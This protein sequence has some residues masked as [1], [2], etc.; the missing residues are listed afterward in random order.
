ML[1]EKENEKRKKNWD[2]YLGHIVVRPL[3]K[4]IIGATLMKHYPDKT[5]RHYTVKRPYPVNVF[6]KELIISSLPY[7]EQDGIVG[8]CAS[9]ALWCAFQHT[10]HLFNSQSH[11]PSD[12][13][14]MA[15]LD[16]LSPT[17]NYTANDLSGEQINNAIYSNNLVPEAKTLEHDIK[18]V[19]AFLYAYLRMGIPVLLGLKEDK[20]GQGHLV[21]LC[22]YRFDNN[23]LKESNKIKPKLTSSQIVKFYAHDD[24]TGPFSRIDLLDEKGLRVRTS[25]WETLKS[26]KRTIMSMD[27]AV[28][29]VAKSIAVPFDDI[30]SATIAVDKLLSKQNYKL[31]FDVFLA[32]S[33]KYKAELISSFSNG[34]KHANNT[35]I[36][37]SSL[38]RYIWVIKGLKKDELQFDILFDAADKIYQLPFAVNVYTNEY[39][40][41]DSTLKQRNSSFFNKIND[42]LKSVAK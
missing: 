21:T 2:S 28:T 22:G 30:L 37:F 18:Y 19:R 9:S 41:I 20:Q 1:T 12:I 35:N 31:T 16:S 34:K 23:S 38:P 17:T 6:G 33:N 26:V 3:P 13:T 10:S 42:I 25:H 32:E 4:G 7:Q 36:L 5:G 39:R 24:Q 40:N 8:S 29:P 11:P 14:I 27:I 15:G